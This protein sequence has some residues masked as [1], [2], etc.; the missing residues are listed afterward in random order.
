M[1]IR[2]LI[3]VFILAGILLMNVRM[4]LAN[5]ASQISIN[6]A[7]TK[8]L[9]YLNIT[10]SQIDGSWGAGL[11][12]IASTATAVLAFENQGHYSWNA[13]DP[14]STNVQNGL[15]FLFAHGENI[16]ISNQTAGNPDTNGNGIGVAWESDGYPTYETPIVLMAIVGS[17]A[18]TNV[19]SAG[20]L[21]VRTYHDIVVDIVD[22]ISWAQ[23]DPS[24]GTARG[25]WGYSENSGSSD[26]SNTAWPVLGLMAAELWGI[27]APPFV[28]NELNYWV[29]TCQDLTGNSTSNSQYGSF[30]YYDHVVYGGVADTSS[31]ILQLTYIG[32][33][34]TNASIIAAEGY[35]NK[36][37]LVNDA[38]WNVNIGNLYAMYAAMKAF[39]EATPPIQFVANYDGTNGVEWYNGTGQY[40]DSLVGNQSLDG[41]WINWSPWDESSNFSLDL[42]TAFAVLILEF[43]PVRVT[44]S[45]TVTVED[46]TNNNPIVG[47]AVQAVGPE[48][49]SGNTGSNGQI[50]FNSVQAGSYQVN[51]SASGY[52]PSAITVS[53]TS[54]TA[55]TIKLSPTTPTPPKPVVGGRV[56][57]VNTLAILVAAVEDTLSKYSVALLAVGAVAALI[58]FKRR[59]K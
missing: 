22:Y 6:T 12:P 47:A 4:P 44:Y 58:I 57:P 59:R 45:L 7:I 27:N 50:T 31:G 54:N 25:G 52:S 32:A 36:M 35:I 46:A 55:V 23:N 24:S 16:T 51:A 53:V 40:A 33:P 20:P 38:S 5:A 11:F 26:N 48:T 34:S 14:Y 3:A 37:W 49:D 42:S 8:G 28:A 1:Y 17:N 19:T 9:A 29:S 10:Q 18:P 21:G 15:N 13:T 30:G 41:H 43:I 39:R 2:E 56:E